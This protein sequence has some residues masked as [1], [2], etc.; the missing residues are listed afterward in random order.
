[1]RIFILF[2]ITWKLGDAMLAAIFPALS[3]ILNDKV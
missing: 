1:V 2:I 3:R